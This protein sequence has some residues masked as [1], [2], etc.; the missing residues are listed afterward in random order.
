MD[1]RAYLSILKRRGWIILATALL[2]GQQSQ[3]SPAPGQIMGADNATGAAKE[4]LA[5]QQRIEAAVVSGDTAFA[6]TILPKERTRD[7][8]ALLRRSPVAA[9]RRRPLCLAQWR[10]GDPG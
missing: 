10:R 2:F 7:E 9:V 6:E 4:V 8:D 5:L 1:L 3:N